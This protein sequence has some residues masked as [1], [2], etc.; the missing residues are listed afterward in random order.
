[1]DNLLE[2][3][4]GLLGPD[5]K[6][7]LSPDLQEIVNLLSKSNYGVQVET[8]P[9][10]DPGVYGEYQDSTKTVRLKPGKPGRI[11]G[12]TES[13]IG[14]ELTHALDYD[15]IKK[16]YGDLTSKDQTYKGLTPEESQFAKGTRKLSAEQTKVPLDRDAE[17]A[18]RRNP[19]EMRAFGVGNFL[20]K[21]DETYEN[22]ANPH[23]DATMA[24]EA[25][26]VR[27]LYS[28][29]LKSQGK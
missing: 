12:V 7:S 6:V 25:A 13:T 10:I 9:N 15:V 18:Y 8:D 21:G 27:D 11:N 28:R 14:H 5:N 19:L 22:S 23:L 1:M 29:L 2:V 4:K 3:V 26:V 16:V 24:S 20:P 17:S